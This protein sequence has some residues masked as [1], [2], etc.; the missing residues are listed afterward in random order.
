MLILC[1]HYEVS[2]LHRNTNW[3]DTCKFT[4]IRF[5]KISVHIY[6]RNVTLQ[7][8]FYVYYFMILIDL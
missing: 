6:L 7:F 5:L 8:C 1:L 2:F 4:E 3:L